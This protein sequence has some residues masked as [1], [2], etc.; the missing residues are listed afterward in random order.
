MNKKTLL[1][2]PEYWNQRYRNNNDTWSLNSANP[3]F[4]QLI[5]GK[6]FPLKEEMLILGCGK[7]HDAYSAAKLGFKVTGIDFSETAIKEARNL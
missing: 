3:V 7:G 2:Q 6:K 1:D 5:S 4:V